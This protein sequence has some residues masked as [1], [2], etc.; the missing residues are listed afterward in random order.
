MAADISSYTD[1]LLVEIVVCFQF[2]HHECRIISFCVYVWLLFGVRLADAE[3]SVA[4][5]KVQ[6]LDTCARS[7]LTK[8]KNI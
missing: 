1:K 2:C 5:H 4:L 6:D 3:F 8:L 7:S